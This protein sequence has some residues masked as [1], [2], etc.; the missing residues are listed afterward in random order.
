MGRDERDFGVSLT[1]IQ[2]NDLTPRLIIGTHGHFDHLMSVLELKLAFNIPFYL[3]K[4]DEFLLDRLDSTAMHFLQLDPGPPPDIDAYLKNKADIKVGDISLKVIHT[5][6]HTPGSICLHEAKEKIIF[7][8]DVIFKD[9]ME[10]RTDFSYS[11]KSKL[12]KSIRL[13]LKLP[14][15]TTVFSGHGEETSVSELAQTFF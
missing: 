8:G 14:K 6:G 4:D 3:H 10:G 9:G 5:P 12:K 7:V 15:E 1:D 11:D 2:R 13:I